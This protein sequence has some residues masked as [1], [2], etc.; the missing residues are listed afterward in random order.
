MKIFVDENIPFITVNKLREQGHDVTDIRN[1]DD[2]GITELWQKAQTQKCLLITTD[3]GFAS[4]REET[5]YGI[6]IVRLKRP[7]CLKIH[8]HIIRPIKKYPQKEW[9]GLMVVKRDAVQSS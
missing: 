1:T 6:L 3:K 9:P 2:Q 8:D 7:T 5:H 4:L